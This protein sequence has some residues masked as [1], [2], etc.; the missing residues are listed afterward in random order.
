M[1][2]DQFSLHLVI[3]EVGVQRFAPGVPVVTVIF[4]D[5]ELKSLDVVLVHRMVG[6]FGRLED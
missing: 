6:D 2:V 3:D 5:V 4:V 1:P